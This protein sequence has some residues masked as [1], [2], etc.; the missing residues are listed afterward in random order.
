MVTR[1][2][3]C[4]VCFLPALLCP[5]LCWDPRAFVGPRLNILRR[6]SQSIAV[7]DPTA[8]TEKH[9]GKEEAERDVAGT[10]GFETLD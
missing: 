9:E 2:L 3:G 5:L 8:P 10:L 7:T 6:E 4:H 1:F